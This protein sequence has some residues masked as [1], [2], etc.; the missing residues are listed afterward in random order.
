[1][2]QQNVAEAGGV[3]LSLDQVHDASVGG[4]AYGLARL[5]G[6]GLAVPPAFVIRDARRGAYPEDL[7]EHHRALGNTTVAVRSSAQGEDGAEASFAGQYETVLG[8]ADG[9]ELR[10]AIDRCVASAA[11]ERARSY[12]A[13]TLEG[14]SVSMNV[15]V[16]RMVDA[17]A[18]GV[19]FTADPV[20]ARR[21]LLV[22]DAVAGLGEALVSGEAT[23]DHY[24]VT[25]DG[26]VVGR[27]LV[28]DAALLS[29]EQIME[30][31]Q[32]A[33]AAA[34]REVQEARRTLAV[35]KER[36][37]REATDH[38]N[39]AVAE[40]K[41][42]VEEAEQRAAAAED[43]ATAATQQANANRSATTTRSSTEPMPTTAWKRNQ[44]SRAPRAPT[45]PM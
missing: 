28:G 4:K 22:I 15:V 31:A 29:D 11:T 26:R 37:A 17:A 18:A 6:M 10:D 43:R 3:I 12:Q 14:G 7:D 36:L 32:Q 33:R 45:K 34:D 39:T 30:I 2:T 13:D 40:T 27:E 42:L 19:V 16:Q 35:E 41:R 38:H 23:P 21:D 8:V 20:S 1:M 5:V 25:L 44:A 24:G 9:H